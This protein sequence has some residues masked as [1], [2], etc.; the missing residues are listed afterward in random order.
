MKIE[1]WE[2]LVFALAMLNYQFSFFNFHFSIPLIDFVPCRT[3]IPACNFLLTP[4]GQ[5][6]I[7]RP[8]FD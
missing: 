1:K 7:V 8:P 4:I 6:P 2:C 5:L 3:G